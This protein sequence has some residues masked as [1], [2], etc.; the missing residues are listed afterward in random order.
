MN[1][2]EIWINF[3]TV[4]V[5]FLFEFYV[6]CFL[7]TTKLRKRKNFWLR[8]VCSL[9]AVLLL[10]F[11]VS[12]FYTYFGNTI[13]G[14]II[15][16]VVLF[17]FVFAQQ[18]F[19]FEE[20]F[21]TILFCTG[22]A[23]A[24]QNL[25]YKLYL[26]QY[27]F[28]KLIGIY[29]FGIDAGGQILYRLMYYTV[30]AVLSSIVFVVFIKKIRDKYALDR[31]N[32]RIFLITLMI[33]AGTIILCSMEDIYFENLGMGVSQSNI[34]ATPLFALRQTENIFSSIYCATI[35]LLMYRTLEQRNLKREVEQLQH[36]IRQS[37]QQYQI[38]KDTIKMIN[39]KCHDLKYRL[40]MAY[41]SGISPDELEDLKNSIAIYDSNIETGNKLL[42]VLFTEKSLYCEKNGIT[43]S[44]MI[45][46]G[47]LSFLQ[48]GDL[49]CLFGNILDNALEAVTKIKEREQRVISVT[50]KGKEDMVILQTENFYVGEIEVNNQLPITTKSD[51]NYHGFGLSSM[52]M[53]AQKYGGEMSIQ[54]NGNIFQLTIIFPTR[55]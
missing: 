27:F 37:E 12:I 25:V 55:K 47:R 5:E 7:L 16:Y 18:W 26:F 39:V 3:G 44:C 43:L 41:R 29:D 40:D 21:W 54:T 28:G 1:M 35:L 49:Y 4:V 22:T 9:V 36:A 24:A 15:V 11:A 38:S 20:S 32:Y 33:L 31:L 52:R 17:A 51:K 13:W 34:Q 6:F 50:V 14:R 45:D 53:I 23:Y 10:S 2:Q 8:I 48:D 42:D 46:G 30:F 19:I